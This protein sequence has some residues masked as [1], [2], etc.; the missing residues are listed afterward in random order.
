MELSNKKRDL[1]T[2]LE[3][4]KKKNIRSIL[5]IGEVNKGKSALANVLTSTD[6]F[7]ENNGI[8]RNKEIRSKEFDKDWLRYRIID[9]GGI[10]EEDINKLKLNSTIN[11]TL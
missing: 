10:G 1:E 8:V 6:H 11:L 2:N 5:I 4:L 3:E 7:Y 9:T